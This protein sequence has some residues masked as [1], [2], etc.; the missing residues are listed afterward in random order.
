MNILF[1]Y[2]NSF[3]PIYGGVQR[4]TDILSRYLIRKGHTIFYLNHQKDEFISPI[5]RFYLPEKDFFSKINQAYY[6][7][8]ILNLDIQVPELIHKIFW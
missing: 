8:I 3:N 1:C 5:K 6:H 4:V 2:K 7:K